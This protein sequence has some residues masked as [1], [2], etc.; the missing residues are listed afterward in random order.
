MAP[1]T[2]TVLEDTQLLVP[3]LGWFLPPSL[4]QG[5]GFPKGLCVWVQI[6][7]LPPIGWAIVG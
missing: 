1:L 4:S 6:P 5:M 3:L 7:A 2:V